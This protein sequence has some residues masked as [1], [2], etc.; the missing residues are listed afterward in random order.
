[1]SIK[2]I[3]TSSIVLFI[4]LLLCLIP[5][6][7]EKNL[8]I[9]TTIQY[10]NQDIKTHTIYLLDNHNYLS[11]TSIKVTEEKTESLAHELLETMIMEGKN[12]DQI[13]SG[14]RA[15]LPN[16]TKI[17]AISF[18]GDTLKIDLS[19]E[20]L[21][22]SKELEEKVIEAIVYTMTSIEEVNYLLLYQDG[23][24]LTFL[25]QNKIT[26]PSTLNR[27]I[28]I[29]KDYHL[30]STKDIQSTTIYYLHKYND[31]FFYT[32]ITT[33]SNDSR[34]KIEIIIDELGS[35]IPKENLMS[36]LNSNAHLLSYAIEDE[37]MIVCFD[38]SIFND[39]ESKDILEEVLYTISLSIYD[40]Y[41]VEEVIFEV[42][43][44]EIAKTDLK[45]LE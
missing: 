28:G 35:S 18:Q 12:S 27:D 17:N 40:N 41:E 20:F 3:V 25:P 14:F 45:S 33:I 2:K 44:E 5:N 6:P 7:E 38:D 32:P 22:V 16:D 30:T 19:K 34:E 10:V 37:K 1:M 36:F 21:E 39:L 26:L 24:L 29:N 42:E 9:K 11:K 43:E 13:P 23:K 8:P 4:L 31:D 15:I